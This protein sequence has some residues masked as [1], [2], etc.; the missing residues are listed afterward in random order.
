VELDMPDADGVAGERCLQHPLG[1]ARR[2]IMLYCGSDK[3][4]CLWGIA[5]LAGE[6][7]LLWGRTC[8]LHMLQVSRGI[9]VRL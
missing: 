8:M 9:Y 5:C 1:C 4:T 6:L 2:S 3:Q 7:V